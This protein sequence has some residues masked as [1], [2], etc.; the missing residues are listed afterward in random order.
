M[1]YP[2]CEL[3]KKHISEGKSAIEALQEALK[4]YM[5][6]NIST[7]LRADV[8]WYIMQLD[9]DS[10]DGNFMPLNH[11]GPLPK[12]LSELLKI[13]II[14]IAKL[15]VPS[16]LVSEVEIKVAGGNHQLKVLYE[17]SIRLEAALTK[18]MPAHHEIET[19]NKLE[20][21][22]QEM[23][24]KFAQLILDCKTEKALESAVE[25]AFSQSSDDY[26]L[27]NDLKV[28]LESQ[29]EFLTN[30]GFIEKFYGLKNLAE[31]FDYAYDYNQELKETGVRTAEIR[32][33]FIHLHFACIAAGY[34]PVES[35]KHE[36]GSQ[37]ETVESVFEK[38]KAYAKEKW[39]R[40]KAY[41][42]YSDLSAK[43]FKDK[44]NYEK[45]SQLRKAL[46]K[47]P[48][49]DE[50]DLFAHAHCTKYVTQNPLMSPDQAAQTYGLTL[51]PKKKKP[52]SVIPNQS[53]LLPAKA[54][55]LSTVGSATPES[56]GSK[57]KAPI[58][59]LCTEQLRD[60][61]DDEMP[62]KKR[63]VEKLQ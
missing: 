33:T 54:L 9:S 6:T 59:L 25:E 62:E 4:A 53:D 48:I 22:M 39:M 12:E 49:G 28:E 55:F 43:F 44:E 1:G 18:P 41:D 30:K 47:N 46:S 35:K 8:D 17:Q 21:L 14:E 26:P 16:A 19:T 40:Y 61:F 13:S 58:S 38:L 34:R 51:T 56:L 5:Q 36:L 52:R 60:G 11:V 15:N 2:S 27:L 63:K 45:W 24:Q 7:E 42:L 10:F 23:R 3:F 20:E 50:D 37:N 29:H 31:K 57:P 32:E